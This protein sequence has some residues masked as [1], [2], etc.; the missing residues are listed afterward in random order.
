MAELN[1][2]VGKRDM[3]DMREQLEEGYSLDAKQK[4]AWLEVYLKL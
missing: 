3:D 1:T 4:K 2:K